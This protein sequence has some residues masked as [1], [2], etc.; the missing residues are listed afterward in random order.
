MAI[1][2]TNPG[3]QILAR[4]S[5]QR[6]ATLIATGVAHSVVCSP[7]VRVV[8]SPSM[9]VDVHQVA[10]IKTTAYRPWA[11]KTMDSYASTNAILTRDNWT[12]AYCEAPASTVDHIVPQSRSG[13]STFGNQVA[14]C[15]DC[16]NAKANRT[17]TEAGMRLLHL[18]YV[19]D[20]WA[21]DQKA[22]YE[23]FS[24]T[25]MS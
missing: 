16:N 7:L 15:F 22:V 13:P 8:R 23:L 10:A 11:G 19:H 4:V 24:L 9:T 1:Y 17:P 5:W 6:A 2:L 3:M 21:E 20:P 14:A 12:C 18:P 25:D